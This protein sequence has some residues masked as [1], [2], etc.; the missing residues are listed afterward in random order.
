MKLVAVL[1]LSILALAGCATPNDAE[2]AASSEA[3]LTSITPLDRVT[4][5][6]IAATYAS[7]VKVGLAAC[8]A[9]HP[10]VAIVD[11][12]NLEV[13]YRVGSEY[14]WDVRQTIEGILD[15]AAVDSIATSELAAKIEPWATRTLSKHV[16]SDGFY[17][18]PSGGQLAFYYAELHTREAKAHALARAPGGKRFDAIRALW[19]DVQSASGTLD[20]SWLRPLKVSTEP[21]LG[22]IRKAMRVPDDVDLESW[23]DAAIDDFHATSEGPNG[24]PEF[25]PLATFLKSSAIQKRWLFQ[26]SDSSGSTSILVVLDEHNQLWGMQMGYSE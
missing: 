14:H 9:G 3:A 6:E 11:R 1:S 26:A 24:A 2:T 5:A 13:F 21:S 8:I 10:A 12:A 23:G 25:E 16:D 19:A 15:D 22:E 18:P 20:S 17:V 7:D 4:P